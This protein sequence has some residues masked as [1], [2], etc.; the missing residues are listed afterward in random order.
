[1]TTVHQCATA[2]ALRNTS[3]DD[4]YAE[5]IKECTYAGPCGAP[6]CALPAQCIAAQPY[7]PETKE[8]TVIDAVTVSETMMRNLHSGGM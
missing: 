7:R 2:H 5:L 3:S 1:M 4:N 6:G 8:N